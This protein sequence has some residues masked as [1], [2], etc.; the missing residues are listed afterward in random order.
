MLVELPPFDISGDGEDSPVRQPMPAV[1]AIAILE[2][3]YCCGSYSDE[4]ATPR[5]M[6]TLAQTTRPRIAQKVVVAGGE[7]MRV[8]ETCATL[9]SGAALTAR[10]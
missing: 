3:H 2:G 6:E 5:V 10:Q 8:P 1:S 9:M 7:D 4:G